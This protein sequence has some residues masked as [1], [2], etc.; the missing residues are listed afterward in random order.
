MHHMLASFCPHK[1]QG[2]VT[3]LKI[4]LT[5]KKLLGWTFCRSCTTYPNYSPNSVRRKFER[6]GGIYEENLWITQQPPDPAESSAGRG[7]G[8]AE[9]NLQF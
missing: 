6:G 1:H 4:F 2:F 3:N 8:T 9:E 5:K 7:S